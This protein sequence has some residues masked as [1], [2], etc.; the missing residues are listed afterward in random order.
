MYLGYAY[1]LQAFAPRTLNEKQFLGMNSW[2]LSTLLCPANMTQ[3]A[4]R[5][6]CQAACQAIKCAHQRTE[7]MGEFT[8]EMLRSQ[9]QQD[10]LQQAPCDCAT[11]ETPGV[12][13]ALAINGCDTA[14][15]SQ[16]TDQLPFHAHKCTKML[17]LQ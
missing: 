9:P 6:K 2:T 3:A 8:V 17:G 12:L 15:H 14:V 16:I 13:A 5:L 7:L 11:L 10:A 1:F 4:S